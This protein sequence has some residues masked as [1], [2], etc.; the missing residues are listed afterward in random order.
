MAWA[1]KVA[2]DGVVKRNWRNALVGI[3]PVTYLY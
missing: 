2:A 1:V 3:A